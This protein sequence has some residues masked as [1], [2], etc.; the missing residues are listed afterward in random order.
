MTNFILFLET[1][2]SPLVAVFVILSF[3]FSS[4][5]GR[6]SSLSSELPERLGGLSAEGR[7]KLAG[8]KVWWFH[9]AS[10]G[11][12]AGLAP[13]LEALAAKPGALALLVTTTTAAGREAARWTKAVTWAQLAP[14]DAWPFVSRFLA[15]A[16]PERLILCE[17]ELW[18]STILLASRARLIPVLINARL[19][20][21]SMARYAWIRGF[22]APALAALEA[23]G[24]QSEPEAERF[25]VLGVPADKITVTG[26]AKY[27]R[28]DVPAATEDADFRLS[29]LNWKDAPLFV[30]GSTHAV[31]EDAVIAGF[32]QARARVPGLRLVL[33]PRHLERGHEADRA[34]KE[35][36]L[37]YFR[38][39]KIVQG[40]SVPTDRE[41]LLVDEFGFLNALYPRALAAFVGGTFVKVGGHNLMEPA[42][43]GVPVLFGPHTGHVDLPAVLLENGGGG[44]RL[45]DAAELGDRLAEL[46]SDPARA[47]GMGGKAKELAGRLRGATARSLAL[48]M[49]V[50]A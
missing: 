14:A 38:W 34:L 5:R 7:A 13:I 2:L 41:A 16:R 39:S 9:A 50:H 28:G 43:A 49:G 17:T 33:A 15:A 3:F 47:R 37:R 4:K 12:V 11:E 35:S 26:N 6:L 32:L 31:E 40:N 20:E 45:R 23:V 42:L 27:D 21:R 46:A 1:L 36:S 29:R 24:A 8:R 30:A 44:Y 18:P 22:L 25:K 10:A 19:T 48:I